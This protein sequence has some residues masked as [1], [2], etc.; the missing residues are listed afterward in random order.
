MTITLSGTA[1]IQLPLGSASAP[2]ETNTTAQTT[3]IYYPSSTT[4]GL[5]TNGT[6][7]VYILS[8]IH[9]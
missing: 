4:L 3:G 6:N 8:L 2:A 5:S 1:G 7:A 9:I